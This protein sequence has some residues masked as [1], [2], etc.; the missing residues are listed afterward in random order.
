MLHLGYFVL[1]LVGCGRIAF[2]PLGGDGGSPGDGAGGSDAFATGPFGMP[3]NITEL[4]SPTA[5]DD[6]PTL[7]ADMLEIY[8]NS[9]RVGGTGG[10]DIWVSR[11]TSTTEAWSVPSPVAELNT[12][13]DESTPEISADGLT[14]WFSSRRPGGAGDYDV[15]I[16]TRGNR[17][18][19]W[20]APVRHGELCTVS[21][22]TGPHVALAGLYGMFSSLRGGGEYDLWRTT[23]AAEADPWLPPTVVTE[24]STAAYEGDPW[25]DESATLLWFARGPDSSTLD[26]FTASRASPVDAWTNVTKVSEL[27]T[28]ATD[29]DPWL[30]P[31]GRTLVFVSSRDGTFD[32]FMATR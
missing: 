10:A 11:R 29:A 7:T 4:S 3:T 18:D 20:G 1:V 14:M 6:D 2:D 17:A 27:A 28:A 22:E 19:M 5:L 26:L 8:F 30:S 25:T 24:L 9:D 21:Q 12:T 16:T 31:D 15:Y 13:V 32:I 23:R